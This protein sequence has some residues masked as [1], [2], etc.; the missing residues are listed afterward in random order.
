MGTC[1]FCDICKKVG[2]RKLFGSLEFGRYSVI[3]CEDCENTKTLNRIILI[4]DKQN[5]N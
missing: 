1:Y 2:E 4:L 5:I 3:I